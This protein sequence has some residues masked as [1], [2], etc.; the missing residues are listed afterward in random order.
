MSFALTKEQMR[1]RTKTVTRRLGWSDLE[2][3]TLLQAVEKARGLAKGA[4]V[5]KLGVIR[6]VSV[7][8][9]SLSRLREARYGRLEAKKEGFP[10]L[11]G[12]EF[13]ERFVEEVGCKP[14]AVVT[15][16]EFE[17]Q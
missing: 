14:N 2:E 13:V 15:R 11:S 10:G 16:I 3:G 1:S 12:R 7:R 9:E 6:V 8:K 17:H 4:A 5:R